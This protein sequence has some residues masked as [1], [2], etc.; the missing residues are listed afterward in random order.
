MAVNPII[1]VIYKGETNNSFGQSVVGGGQGSPPK[2]SQIIKATNSK[3]FFNKNRT[4]NK[5]LNKAPL[6]KGVLTYTAIMQTVGTAVGIHTALNEA[7]TG[8]TVANYNKRQGMNLLTNPIGFSIKSAWEYGVL[9]P[10]IIERQSEMLMY[11]RRL[12]GNI[13][14]GEGKQ[15]GIF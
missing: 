15:R 6:A 5:L 11:D 14:Y 3:N 8:N 2:P 7:R 4:M 10:K 13:I 1:T 12:T 9:Q